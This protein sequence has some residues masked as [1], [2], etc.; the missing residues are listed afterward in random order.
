MRRLR[1]NVAASLDGFIAGVSG[2]YDWI[3]Q[4]SSID[5]DALFAE[6]DLLV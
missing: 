1:Y 4:D 5:F 6:F 3:V 2:D